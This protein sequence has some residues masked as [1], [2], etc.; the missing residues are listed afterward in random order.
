MLGHG[1][2]LCH[3]LKDPRSF[4]TKYKPLFLAFY[5]QCPSFLPP[6]SLLLTLPKSWTPLLET[7]HI[8]LYHFPSSLPLSHFP[9][10]TGGGDSC[11]YHGCLPHPLGEG[12]GASQ[13]SLSSCEERCAP[14]CCETFSLRVEDGEPDREK[15]GC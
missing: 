8:G 11:C 9:L 6:G 5:L 3:L 14:N 2:T 12:V 4:H 15:L 10:M 13:P 7:C 1:I